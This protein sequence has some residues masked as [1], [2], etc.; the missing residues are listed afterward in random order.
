MTRSPRCTRKE[1]AG[2]RAL[3]QAAAAA[4]EAKKQSPGRKRTIKEMS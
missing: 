3:A 1:V 2:A 4:A